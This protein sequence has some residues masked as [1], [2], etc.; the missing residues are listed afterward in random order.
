MRGKRWASQ[1]YFARNL[2]FGER[3]SYKLID[4]GFIHTSF[5][6]FGAAPRRPWEAKV[7]RRIRPQRTSKRYCDR[8]TARLP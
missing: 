7:G 4:R 5:F 3:G 1:K 8:P 2:P 6:L